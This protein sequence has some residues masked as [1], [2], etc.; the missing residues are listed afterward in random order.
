MLTEIKECVE[1]EIKNLSNLQQNSINQNLELSVTKGIDEKQ[2]SIYL[3]KI[4]LLSNFFPEFKD[5]YI[6]G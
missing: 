1:E 3:D 2:V 6:E 4:N 5:K